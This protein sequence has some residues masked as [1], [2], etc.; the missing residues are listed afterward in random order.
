MVN[1]L[2]TEQKS[3][4]QS[5]KLFVA[6]V[7]LSQ[8]NW[9]TVHSLGPTAAEHLSPNWLYYIHLLRIVEISWISCVHC[10]LVFVWYR[11]IRLCHCVFYLPLQTFTT[12]LCIWDVTFGKVVKISENFHGLARLGS[13][14]FWLWHIHWINSV[15]GFGSI[16]I[17]LSSAETFC[18]SA[19]VAL[20]RL[21]PQFR[22]IANS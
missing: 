5:L 12:F 13:N 20:S 2:I 22:G 1:D 8:L 21:T 19:F 9:K 18:S 14:I 17:R 11:L 10:I 16:K 3:L 7:G 4:K 6:N 15:Y